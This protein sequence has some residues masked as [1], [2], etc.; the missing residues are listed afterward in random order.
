MVLESPAMRLAFIKDL[1]DALEI[2]TDD[3]RARPPGSSARPPI[4]RKLKIADS[5]LVED[6]VGV[7]LGFE[8]LLLDGMR[9]V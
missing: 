6:R 9:G 2:L 3:V 8:R 1:R 5:A 7:L 4:F